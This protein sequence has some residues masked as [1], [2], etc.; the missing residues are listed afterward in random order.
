M[1]TKN[2]PSPTELTLLKVLWNQQPL[3]AREIHSAAEQ[4]LAWSYSSTR[5]TLERMTEKGFL[6]TKDVHGIKVFN[7]KLN[8]VTTLA[9]Y[10]K[11]FAKSVLEVDSPLPV[12]M[13]A[14]SKLLD[15]NELDALEKMLEEDEASKT[16]DS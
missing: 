9:S 4:Q 1:N 2:K 13:F 6:S 16:S 14:D 11:D 15:S 5:K 7:A 12:A 3:S 10:I 8:K